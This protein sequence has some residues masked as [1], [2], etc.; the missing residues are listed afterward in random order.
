MHT[1]PPPVAVSVIEA[2]RRMSIGRSK[3]WELIRAGDLPAVRIGGR[4]LVRVADVDAFLARHLT[5]VA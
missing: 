5:T 1:I 3:T 2:A 4:T